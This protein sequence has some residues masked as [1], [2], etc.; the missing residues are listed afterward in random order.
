MFPSIGDAIVNL[1]DD[2]QVNFLRVVTDDTMLEDTEELMQHDESDDPPV[3]SFSFIRFDLSWIET[4][5]K[6]NLDV[7]F[8][9]VMGAGASSPLA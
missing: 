4:A 6:I 5:L 2:P 8:M 3:P 7:T 1:N 9:T